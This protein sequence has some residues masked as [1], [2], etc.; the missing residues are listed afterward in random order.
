MGDCS[1]EVSV[2]CNGKDRLTQT[3]Y[4]SRGKSVLE[5]QDGF[6]S[7]AMSIRHLLTSNCRLNDVEKIEHL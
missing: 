5:V 2:A 1:E 6:D 7:E 4:S 3:K